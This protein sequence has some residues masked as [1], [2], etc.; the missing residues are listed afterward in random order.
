M[1]TFAVIDQDED[2]DE[3]IDMTGNFSHCAHMCT[4]P[5]DNYYIGDDDD[6]SSWHE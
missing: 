1:T 6:E 4:C 2:S 5:Y 3:Q